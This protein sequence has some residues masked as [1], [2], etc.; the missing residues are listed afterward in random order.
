MVK[1]SRYCNKECIFYMDSEEALRVLMKIKMRVEADKILVDYLMKEVITSP[2]FHYKH[3][4]RCLNIGADGLAKK[5][6]DIESNIQGW[7]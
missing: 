1:D 3:V 6:H 4:N 2:N 7:F 5:G